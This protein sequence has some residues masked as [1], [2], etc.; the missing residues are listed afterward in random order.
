MKKTFKYLKCHPKNKSYK[1]CLDDK[2]IKLMKYIWN[3][4]HPD[5]KIKPTNTNTIWNQ[6]KN[7]FSNSC[8]N[9]IC[10][11]D[12]TINN[13]NYKYNLKNKL[14]APIA[15]EE[16][17]STDK[18]SE[19]LS[20]VD[21]SKV[22]K[23]Y[24]QTYPTF[25]F[26]GPSPIDYDSPN[27]YNNESICVW[28]EL[29]HFDLN[30]YLN[31]EI[32]G[33]VFNTDKHYQPGTHWISL[34]VDLK[35]NKIFYF[36]SAGNDPPNKIKKLIQNIK[37][38]GAN[39]NID[40]KIDNNVGNPHQQKDGECGMYSLYFI[41]NIVENKKSL[42]YFKHKKVPDKLVKRFRNIYFNRL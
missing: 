20:S 6:L 15:P 28:P 19:W 3:K 7:K 33:F 30:K 12:N 23:Q 8:S 16:W 13:Y 1:K 22:L 11:I 41:I 24:E 37:N 4:R 17:N 40:F 5:D 34:V 18:H 9:E 38:Q 42:N 27:R 32:I 26:I 25:S 21:I 29:C 39:L 14:F 10:W 2:T 31:K 35:R 36:D